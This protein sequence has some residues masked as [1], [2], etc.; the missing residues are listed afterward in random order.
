M[1]H[2]R[3]SVITTDRN[4]DSAKTYIPMQSIRHA[5]DCNTDFYNIKIGKLSVLTEFTD[6]F[7]LLDVTTKCLKNR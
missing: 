5:A 1:Y 4:F 2:T 3:T 7:N 6:R